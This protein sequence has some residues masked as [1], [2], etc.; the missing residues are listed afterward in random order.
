MVTAFNRLLQR[1][2]RL[3]LGD[4]YR[5]LDQVEYNAFNRR[6]YAVEQAA[7]Y[8]VGAQIPGDYFEFGVYQGRTFAHACKLM[9]TLFPG[10]RFVACDSFEGLPPPQGL[11]AKDGYTSH[12]Y[13]GQFSCTK[14]EFLGNLKREGVDLAR[15]VTIEGWFDRSLTDS[16][17]ATH[18]LQRIAGAWIDCDLYESTIP[19]LEFITPM[20]SVGSV[21][22]FDDWRCFRNHPDFGQQR[23]L[24]EWLAAN[25]KFKLAELF[26]FGWNGLAF[27]VLE[28]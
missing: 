16:T 7:E 10:I 8:L 1:I 17:R 28:C 13:Q 4:V 20:L 12:F 9:G 27:T 6:F 26:S 14:D 19:V 11:D 21:L 23:A 5:R 18:G 3:L 2:G 15:V 25:Q 22:L 24:R